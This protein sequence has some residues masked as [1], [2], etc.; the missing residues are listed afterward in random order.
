VVQWA[1][2]ATVR[3]ASPDPM[4]RDLGVDHSRPGGS[5]ALNRRLFKDTDTAS[6]SKHAARRGDRAGGEGPLYGVRLAGSRVAFAAARRPPAGGIA[7]IAL[8]LGLT[9]YELDLRPRADP[10]LNPFPAA[11]GQLAERTAEMP[12]PH[13]PTTASAHVP[14]AGSRSSDGLALP[15][16]TRDSGWLISPSDHRRPPRRGARAPG[17]AVS[18]SSGQACLG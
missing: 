15:V 10:R 1:Q 17:S 2:V 11:A 16:A 4:G 6:D 8:M 5:W 7:A 13:S 12:A 9:N 3:C 18:G 14:P